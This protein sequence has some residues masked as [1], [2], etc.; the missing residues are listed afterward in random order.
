MSSA[1]ALRLAVSAALSIAAVAVHAPA[2]AQTYPT[3]PVTIVVPLAAGTGMDLLVRLYGEQLAQT[4][5][6]P[7]VV[8]NKPGAALALG[9]TALGAAP[10]DGH[11]LGVL[12]SAPLAIGPVLY[13]SIN[14]DPTG[15]APIHLYVKSPL[16]LVVNPA[17]PP[18]SVS[19]FI[20]FAKASASPLSYGT[21][22]AGAFQHLST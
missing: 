13:K 6:K 10:P 21:P 1:R 7:V 16:V 2:G 22:G 14:Y 20:Q 15:F 12:T 17:L 11:T 5:G 19:E 18:K 4:L 8:E 9:A 3:K